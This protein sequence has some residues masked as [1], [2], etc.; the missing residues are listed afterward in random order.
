MPFELRVYHARD[1][2]RWLQCEALD[3]AAA[4]RQAQERG[5]TVLAL[6]RPRLALRRG[7]K[8]RVHWFAQELLAL[9]DAGMGLVEAVDILCS[10]ARDSESRDVLQRVA[11]LLKEGSALSAALAH[12]P[13]RFPLLFAATI[14]ASEQT[15]DLQEALRRY[16]AY[17]R[18]LNSVREQLVSASIYPLMLLAV[19]LLVTLF[20]LVYV[21]PR[22][23]KVYADLGAERIPAMSRLLMHWG[24][25]INAHGG[26]ML[27]GAAA[28]L[29][30]AAWLGTRPALR[31]ALQR[32]LWR[33][34]R[35]GQ[36]VRTY[37]LA[38]F[39]RTVAMLLKG[40]VPL[41]QALD[42]TAGLLRQPAMRAALL[43]ARRAISEGMPLA[44]S[45]ACH[46]LATEV[47]VR[48]LIV[49]ERS[50][51]LGATMERIADFYDED[52]A[53]EVA[54][55]SRV[56]EPALMAVIGLVI[57]GIVVLMYLPIFELAGAIQ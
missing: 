35:L 7:G 47:G 31:A 12:A 39:T 46:G 54:W 55:F 30:L 19:G 15:G 4:R 43:A 50:G 27:A 34:P 11:A 28:A 20:L 29:A 13:D 36:Q 22:F 23:G 37:H 17:H 45:I 21:V 57:G 41:V 49:G 38:R 44:D 16:L 18:Q 10:K 9:L 5:Y 42:M 48:L 56:F 52:I 51:D 6:R 8:F 32:A 3:E 25:L 40:G 2:I 33:L 1:G 26:A 53:R 14:Q 24:E